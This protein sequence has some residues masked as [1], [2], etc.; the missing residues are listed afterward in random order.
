MG[1][2]L[3]GKHSICLL[4]EKEGK[5]EGWKKMINVSCNYSNVQVFIKSYVTGN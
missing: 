2:I 1:Y 5:I 4:E 3:Q